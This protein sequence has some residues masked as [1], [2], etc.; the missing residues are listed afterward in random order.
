MAENVA[1]AMAMPRR[2]WKQVESSLRGHAST[3]T[4]TEKAARRQPI[5]AICD[6]NAKN[7]TFGKSPVFTFSGTQANEKAAGKAAS[8]HKEVGGKEKAAAKSWKPLVLG[9]AV[10][11]HCVERQWGG[12]TSSC[13][14]CRLEAMVQLL[15]LL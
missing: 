13:L 3:C 1:E 12:V 14:R 4:Q 9:A 6:A 5:L 11:S 7:R 15:S 8:K 10:V 2:K